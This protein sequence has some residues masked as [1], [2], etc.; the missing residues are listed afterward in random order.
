M[1]P[2]LR[3]RGRRPRALPRERNGEPVRLVPRRRDAGRARSTESAQTRRKLV[4]NARCSVPPA[5][6]TMRRCPASVDLFPVRSNKVDARV[7]RLAAS[8]WSVLDVDELRACGLSD[9]AI[10]ACPDG[11]AAPLISR[12]LRLGPRQALARRLFLAAVK[13]CGDG[14]VLSHYSAAVLCGAG[15]VGLPRPQVT[16]PTRVSTRHP[17]PPSEH[18]AHVPQGH[19]RHSPAANADRPL[20]DAAVHRAAPSGQRSPQPAARSSPTNSSPPTTE[21]P[22]DCAQSSP[23]APP[24]ATSSKTSSRP[25]RRPPEAAG[26]PAPP[27]LRPRLPLARA[28]PHPR[29]RRRRH[30]RPTA[31]PR[32][33][34]SPPA[35]LEANGYESSAESP[36]AR[37]PPSR[38]SCRPDSGPRS[39]DSQLFGP[40]GRSS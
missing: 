36:G 27:R 4:T 32:R 10:R 16:A 19:P 14:A 25:P 26:Q 39:P 38:P 5:R 24:R 3:C 34:Q 9:N 18:R 13:A 30:P 28:P 15:R 1:R 33:R 31:R 2:P 29:S 12:C 23:Q 6:S 8:Q 22:S 37:P 20:L 11:P 40:L 21:A 17:H 7:R 35:F